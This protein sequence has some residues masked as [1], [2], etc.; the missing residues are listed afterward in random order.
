MPQIEGC[1]GS[2]FTVE[3][4]ILFVEDSFERALPLRKNK[5]CRL[6]R[7]PLFA[8]AGEVEDVLVGVFTP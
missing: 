8:K 5:V 4:K 1:T 2:A 7:A 6:G 3:T